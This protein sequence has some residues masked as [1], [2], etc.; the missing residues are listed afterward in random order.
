MKLPKPR[1]RGNSW[2]ISIMFNGKHEYCTRDTKQESLH[3]AM[4]KLIESN[5]TPKNEIEENNKTITTFHDFFSMYYKSHGR[6]T[7]S[8]KYIREQLDS[9]EKRFAGLA[10]KDITAR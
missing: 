3:W 1:K 10:A 8:K 2:S 9:F 4:N 6:Q 7:K 5:S